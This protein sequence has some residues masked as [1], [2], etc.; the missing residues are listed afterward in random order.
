MIQQLFIY[1]ISIS[2][3]STAAYFILKTL[4]TKSFDF[5]LEKYKSDINK[6]LESH[7][8][9]LQLDIEKFKGELNIASIEHNITFSKLQEER[10]NVIKTT[11]LKL[12][13]LSKQ[14]QILTS[15]FQGP[16]WHSDREKDNNAERAFNDLNNYIAFNRIFYQNIFVKKYY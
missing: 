1:F 16:Q 7:K 9:K 8:Q 10:A 3:I 2:G 13:E 14:L 4:I 11:Y 15:M 12:V 5:A 6:E